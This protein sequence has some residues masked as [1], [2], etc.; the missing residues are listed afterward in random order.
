MKARPRDQDPS[1]CT[2]ANPKQ[3]PLHAGTEARQLAQGHTAEQTFTFQF[4]EHLRTQTPHDSM[5]VRAPPVGT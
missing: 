1:L 3:K 2:Q 5:L 4:H